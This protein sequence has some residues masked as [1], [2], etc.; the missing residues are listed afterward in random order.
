MLLGA[1][2]EE[3]HPEVANVL[4]AALRGWRGVPRVHR[5]PLTKSPFVASICEAMTQAGIPTGKYFGNSFHIGAATTAAQ[6]CKIQ[7]FNHW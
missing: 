1:T 6:T 7:L 4:F 5:T 3:L 2:G